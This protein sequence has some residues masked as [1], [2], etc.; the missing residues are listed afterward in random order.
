[1]PDRRTHLDALAVVLLVACCALWGL[2]H[3]ITKLTLADVPPLLQAGLRS[4]GA[5]VLVAGWAL[6]RG[7]SLSVRNG[8]LVG[9]LQFTEASRMIVFI[10]LSPFVVALGMPLIARSERPQ[11][12]QLLGLVLA[13]SGVFW[14]FAEGLVGHDAAHPRRWIGD[15]LGLLAAVLWGSNTL[16]IRGS[17]LA[18]ASPVQTLF[19]QLAVSG[20]ML[21]AASLLA[22]EVWPAPSQLSLRPWL[23][24]G[25]QTVVVTSVSYLVW[26][27]LLRRYPATRVTAF[28]LLTPMFGLWAGVALLGEPLTL[29]LAVACAAVALGIGL[30]NR[31]PRVAAGG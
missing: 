19:Y 26:F 25:F 10:Y 13:F 23:L 11:P 15:A 6:W 2:N 24:L 21:V 20:P 28:T 12:L 3:A 18:T 16:V 1:M 7:V 31:P 17:K 22:G 30:V 9:G 5:A 4:L 14:A 8:T 27:W 29:R